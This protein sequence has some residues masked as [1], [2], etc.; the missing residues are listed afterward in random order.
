MSA[1]QSMID[2]WFRSGAIKREDYLAALEQSGARPTRLQWRAMLN[3]VLLVGAVLLLTSALIFF[4]AYNW[5]DMHRLSKLAVA[6]A[7]LLSCSVLY[8]LFWRRPWPAKATLLGM[9]VLLGAWMALY[10]Q[11][12]QTGVDPWQLFAFWGLLITPWALVS[13]S[14]L[15]WALWWLLLNTAAVLYMQVSRGF[16]PLW[17][18]SDGTLWVSFGLNACMAV[19]FALMH[20]WR[21]RWPWSLRGRELL[22][23]SL[24]ACGV[25]LSWLAIHWIFDND[26]AG[27]SALLAYLLFMAGGYWLF[28]LRWR[29]LLMSSAW[30]LSLIVVG[31]FVLI[32]FMQDHLESFGLLLLAI[33]L[34]ASSVMAGRWLMRLHGHRHGG[35]AADEQA[36]DAPH[37]AL[38]ERLSVA[39]LVHGERPEN[40]AQDTP[41]AVRILLGF[42]GWL[43]S[44]LLLAFIGVVFTQLLRSDSAGLLATLA[45]LANGGA[46]LMLSQGRRNEFIAQSALAVS[47]CGQLMMSW[48]LFHL[49]DWAQGL[50]V[51]FLYQAALALLMP[52][53]VHRVASAAFAVLSL[54]FSLS[55]TGVHVFVPVGVSAALVWLWLN[56]QRWVEKQRIWRPVAYGLMLGLLAMNLFYFTLRAEFRH[57][58]SANDAWLVRHAPLLAS[59]LFAAVL[60]YLVWRLLQQLGLARQSARSGMVLLAVAALSVMGFWVAGSNGAMIV[61]L[62]GFYLRHWTFFALGVLSWL[63]AVGWF[64]YTLQWTLLDKSFLL[65]GMGLLW[66]AIHLWLRRG[67]EADVDAPDGD[68]FSD[69][70]RALPG[71]ARWIALLTLLLSVAAVNFSTYKKEKL[72]ESGQLVLLRLAPVDPR[73]MMQGDYM[74]LR[75]A[76]GNEILRGVKG[77]EDRDGF[78]R[79]N[80]NDAQVASLDALLSEAEAVQP[81][82]ALMRYRVR[83]GRVRL[84][85]DGYYFQEGRAR[86]FDAAQ[87]GAFRVSTDGEALLVNL[88]D[89]NLQPLDV[90]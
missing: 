72:L 33:Y 65:A 19:F 10:G 22:K 74:R 41:M 55:E 36:L 56:P 20:H 78:L 17:F 2:H 43:A 11:I 14:A 1:I 31:L 24:M 49:S 3:A 88:Y 76:L 89:E 15:V 29:D 87:Y 26:K 77:R 71:S 38:W 47:L 66:L 67:V 21:H 44:L 6:Q 40:A 64:Y 63:L 42:S 25:V 4:F 79:L 45:L 46:W 9:S 39:R 48:A 34:V 80:L 61:T 82:Q 32:E 8:M 57:L 58:L 73:S 90:R 5:A 84:A 70:A 16:L 54:S 68:V 30:V 51:M 81:T 7:A 75:Y 52:H 50:M 59:I 35:D 13:R 69:D 86:H 53:F 62:L 12:Y 27:A 60:L 37:G 23:L 83:N 28:Y 85:S 18:R